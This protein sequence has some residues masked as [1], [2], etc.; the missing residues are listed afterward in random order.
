VNR[1]VKH[2]MGLGSLALGVAGIVRPQ[3]FRRLCDATEDEARELGVR[4]LCVGVAIYASPRVGLAQRAL[5]D[6]GDAVVFGRRKRIVGVVAVLSAL[7]A[8]AAAAS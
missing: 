5:S 6:L 8:A 1:A 7:V 2:A 4:D 3:L